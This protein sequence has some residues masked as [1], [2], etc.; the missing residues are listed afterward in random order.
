LS[1]LKKT[2]EKELESSS[3]PRHITFGYV[4]QVVFAI[5]GVV[6]PLTYGS[7]SGYLDDNSNVVAIVLFGVGLAMTF[8]YIISEVWA[9]LHDK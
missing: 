6:F 4:S 3:F 8:S 9:A 1:E 2:Y 7:W 5:L